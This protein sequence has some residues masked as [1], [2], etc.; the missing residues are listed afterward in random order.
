MLHVLDTEHPGCFNDNGNLFWMAGQR[1]DTTRNS[2]FIWRVK[3][4]DNYSETVTQMTFTNWS[5]SQPSP[6]MGAQSCAYIWSGHS[7]TWDNG[8]CRYKMCS[9]CEL[10]I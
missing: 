10:D 3:S 6:D 9:V 4:T 5:P 8:D 2:E 7:Y 1:V